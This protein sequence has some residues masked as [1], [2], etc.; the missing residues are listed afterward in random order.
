MSEQEFENEYRCRRI[1]ND[2]MQFS[3]NRWAAVIKEDS[4]V[5]IVKD[6]HARVIIKDGET[7]GEFDRD[8]ENIFHTREAAEKFIENYPND[9]VAK[10]LQVE[11]YYQHSQTW[12]EDLSEPTALVKEVL[13]GNDKYAIFLASSTSMI[14]IKQWLEGEEDKETINSLMESKVW[15]NCQETANTRD[16]AKRKAYELKQEFDVEH[17]NT[18]F[19]DDILEK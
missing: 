10:Y 14:E 9:E 13:P 17:C 6:D 19:L 18:K 11:A 1:A 8:R 3:P 12:V 15:D 5:K 2:L 4:G 7:I 16:E